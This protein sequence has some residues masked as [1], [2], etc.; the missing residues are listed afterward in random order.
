MGSLLN[1]SHRDLSKLEGI[2][3]YKKIPTETNLKT[4]LLLRLV[5]SEQSGINSRN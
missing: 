5:S 3:F 1:L 4:N 2:Y